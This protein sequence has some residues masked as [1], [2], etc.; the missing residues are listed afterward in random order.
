MS[1]VALSKLLLSLRVGVPHHE[2]STVTWLPCVWLSGGLCAHITQTLCAQWVFSVVLLKQDVYNMGHVRKVYVAG[3][4]LSQ[5][6]S[7]W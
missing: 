3:L 4:R 5:E 7:C 6:D 2:V 1:H